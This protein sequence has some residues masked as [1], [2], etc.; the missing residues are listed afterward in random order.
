[1]LKSLCSKTL[2]ASAIIAFSSAAVA[3]DKVYKL[4]LAETWGPNFPVFG[5][6]VKNMV[7]MADEMSNGRLKIRVDSSNKHKAPFGVFDLVKSGQ[8]DLGHTASYY[9]KGKVPNTLYFTTMPFGMNAPE[10][11]AWLQYG[12]GQDLMNQV[13]AEHNLVPF[14]GGNTGV[15]MGGWF[16]KEIN[17]V[18][19]LQN[20]KMRIPGFAGEVLAKLGATPVNIPPGELYTALERNTIDA[21]EWVGPSLDLRMGFHKIAPYYYMGWHEP[22]TELMFIANKKKL[23]K[24]PEDLQAILAVAMR[25]AAYDMFI[26]SYAESAKNWQTML[27]EYPNIQVKTFPT[28]VIKALKNANDDLLKEKAAADPMAAKIIESQQ[29]YMKQVR[30]YTAISEQGYLNSTE[31]L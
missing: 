30:A 14:P 1:M 23:E 13:Y 21:L 29:Q 8:Y 15:Q 5:D 17:S 2:L 10:Q 9:Y 28:E 4:K 18:E 24:M 19:D 12:G 3:A 27:Q 16:R 20:L 26:H 31:G 22:A 6:A 7:K 25:K 11:H